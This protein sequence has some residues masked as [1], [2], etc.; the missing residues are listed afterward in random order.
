MFK[1]KKLLIL[2]MKNFQKHES[3]VIYEDFRVL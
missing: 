3:L 1:N 2:F